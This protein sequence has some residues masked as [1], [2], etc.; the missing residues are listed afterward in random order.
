MDKALRFGPLFRWYIVVIMSLKI[1]DANP[2]PGT[3]QAMDSIDEATY[4]QITAKQDAS[5]IVIDARGDLDLVTVGRL[6]DQ[7]EDSIDD[8]KNLPAGKLL[9]LDLTHLEFIDSAGL[10]LLIRISRELGVIERVLRV[11][12]TRGRQPDRVLK[13]GQFY[14]I[15][16]LAYEMSG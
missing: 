9:V 15:L 1:S 4:L 14:R 8:L 5:G 13:I 10:A 3:P 2:D 16:D 6:D 7:I 12:V 11:V